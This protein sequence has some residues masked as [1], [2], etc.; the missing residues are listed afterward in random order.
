SAD[1]NV[2]SI[3]YEADALRE[4]AGEDALSFAG[5]PRSER[6]VLF[7]AMTIADVGTATPA[8]FWLSGAS[9]TETDPLEQRALDRPP[10]AALAGMGAEPGRTRLIRVTGWPVGAVGTEGAFYVN[11]SWHVMLSGEG[12]DMKPPSQSG[13]TAASPPMQ[14][15]SVHVNPYKLPE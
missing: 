6:G 15:L 5:L 7:D 14:P 3:V 8:R 4:A 13:G 11:A 12:S 2:A 10:G 9:A 1:Q